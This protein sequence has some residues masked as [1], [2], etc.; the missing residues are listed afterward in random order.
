MSRPIS[1]LGMSG[2]TTP[3]NAN[4]SNRFNMND[5]RYYVNSIQNHMQLLS[6][7]I[8]RLQKQLNDSKLE[9]TNYDEC[10]K[11]SEQNMKQLAGKIKNIN[12][13]MCYFFKSTCLLVWQKAGA[14]NN[15]Q[16]LKFYS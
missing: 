4:I 6:D 5:K 13:F 7:E 9:A 2:F 16:Q 11:Q 10:K 15:N 12:I 14:F 3:G 8:N 1:Q